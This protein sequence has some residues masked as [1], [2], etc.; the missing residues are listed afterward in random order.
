VPSVTALGGSD[1]TLYIHDGRPVISYVGNLNERMFIASANMDGTSWSTEVFL[2]STRSP[3]LPFSSDVVS[4]NGYVG[5]GYDQ[6]S[7]KFAYYSSACVGPFNPGVA[8]VNPVCDG[9]TVTLSAMGYGTLSWYNASSGGTYLG[10]GTSF[11]TPSLSSTTTYYVQDSTCAASTRTAV[12]VTVNPLPTIS[13]AGNLSYCSGDSTTLSVNGSGDG[14]EWSTG[15]LAMSE[16]FS[17]SVTTSEWVMT[18]DGAGCTDTIFFTINV[19]QPQTTT[20]TIAICDGDSYT[21]GSNSYSVA[22]T[23]TDSLATVQL[24]CDS[25]VLTTITVQPNIDTTLSYSNGIL[26]SNETGAVYQWINCTTQQTINGATNQSYTPTQNGTYAAVIVNGP[27]TDTSTC[28]PVTDVGISENISGN[29]VMIVNVNAGEINST[30]QHA[31]GVISFEYYNA[32]GELVYSVSARE[33]DR[34]TYQTQVPG[35]YVVKATFGGTTV[36]KRVVA[37]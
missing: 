16:S 29:A 9:S 7:D 22:G 25:I 23:Y 28:Y 34:V 6:P 14:F 30:L 37:Q 4:A 32:L 31:P 17:P 26:S 3:F 18:Y 21:V 13:L 5:V 1:P 2:D 19:T 10:S 20:Q 12:T 33:G 36:V 24:G 35:M 15:S 11:T 8:S 27:C